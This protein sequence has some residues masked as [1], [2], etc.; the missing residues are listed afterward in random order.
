MKNIFKILCV[1][2]FNLIIAGCSSEPTAT[3]SVDPQISRRPAITAEIGQ[4]PD[5]MA[6]NNINAGM[7]EN[8]GEQEQKAI[9]KKPLN[10]ADNEKMVVVNVTNIGR[11]DPFRPYQE[12]NITVA[13]YNIPPPP[14]YAPDPAIKKLI[15]VKVNGILYDSRRPSAIVNI[16]NSDYL[17]HIGDNIFN[18]Y[19]QDIIPDRVIIRYGNNTYR[20]G[21][22]EIIEGDVAVNPVNTSTQAFGG[23]ASLTPLPE[24]K[25]VTP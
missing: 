19:I 14:V 6:A 2:L 3:V 10:Y 18:Y 11:K 21:I 23:T 8:R 1:V 25:L 17:V 5:S 24:I 20:A 9:D 16:N 13:S 15:Q 4:K 12:R 22:G 7:E